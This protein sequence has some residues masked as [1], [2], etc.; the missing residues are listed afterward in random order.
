MTTPSEAD[1]LAA[2]APAGRTDKAGAPSTEWIFDRKTLTFLGTR[3][4]QVN[5]GT[6]EDAL[7]KPGTVLYTHAVMVRAFVDDIKATP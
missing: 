7:I 3:S 1:A 2:R 4:V 5:P 6:G